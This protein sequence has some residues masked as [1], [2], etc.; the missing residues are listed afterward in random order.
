M[1]TI[2]GAR[3]LPLTIWRYIQDKTNFE[4]YEK[5][6]NRIGVKEVCSCL[7]KAWYLRKYKDYFFSDETR[8][9]IFRGMVFDDIFSNLYEQNGVKVVTNVDGVDIV[10]KI[11]FIDEF[12]NIWEL[13]TVNSIWS[14][15][16][17][18]YDEH[19]LQANFYAY[20]TGRDEFN[21]LYVSFD[22]IRGFTNIPMDKSSAEHLIE[23]AKMLNEYLE[24]DIVPPK[25]ETK[26]CRY[27]QYYHI[28]MRDGNGQTTEDTGKD[29]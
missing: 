9:I 3:N 18:P 20:M 15:K 28:C 24:K 5:A 1:K 21:L 17:G 16:N 19:V 29:E 23:R 6:N 7:R 14:V 8:W 13:K 27:C 10:G 11:D 12:D 4:Y 22:G 26:S 25:E 2:I